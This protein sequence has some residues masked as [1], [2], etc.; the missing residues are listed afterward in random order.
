[1]SENELPGGGRRAGGDDGVCGGVRGERREG[2]GGEQHIAHGVLHHRRDQS[3]D[4]TS[5]SLRIVWQLSSRDAVPAPNARRVYQAAARSRLLHVGLQLNE[6]RECPSRYSSDGRSLCGE[7][8][9]HGRDL[10]QEWLDLLKRRRDAGEHARRLRV[11][12]G[13]VDHASLSGRDGVRQGCQFGRCDG[14]AGHLDL[15]LQR[16]EVGRAGLGRGQ[17]GRCGLRCAAGEKK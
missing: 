7:N 4:L 16:H 14:R 8:P 10:R 6:C 5:G 15:L 11:V 13:Q 3:V 12:A 1:M 2:G 17:G 9:N